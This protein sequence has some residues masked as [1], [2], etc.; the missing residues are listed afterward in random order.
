[1]PLPLAAQC[2]KKIVKWVE[3]VSLD[4]PGIDMNQASAE[5]MKRII[6]NMYSDKYFVPVFKKKA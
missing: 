4:Y 3:Q 2:P 5:E 6:Y 1:M